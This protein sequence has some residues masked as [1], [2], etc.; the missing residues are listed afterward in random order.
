MD[1][2]GEGE[3]A[4]T[5]P[6][7]S[8]PAYAVRVDHAHVP[9]RVLLV[10]CR[11]K[12]GHELDGHGHGVHGPTV[13]GTSKPPK[14]VELDGAVADAVA[15]HGVGPEGLDEGVVEVR[16]DVARVCEAGQVVV[17]AVLHRRTQL[18]KRDYHLL[19]RIQLGQPFPH[20]I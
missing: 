9:L 15:A 7:S 10:L 16:V 5:N 11:P 18:N 17:V 6:G 13:W 8:S 2:K 19:C 14:P 20:L 12:V 3:S 4:S 1:G